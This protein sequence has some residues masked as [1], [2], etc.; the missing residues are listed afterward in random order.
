MTGSL[1]TIPNSEKCQERCLVVGDIAAFPS[2]AEH[3][4]EVGFAMKGQ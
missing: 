2:G 3:A 1:N 4:E